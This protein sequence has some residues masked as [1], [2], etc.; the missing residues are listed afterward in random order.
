MDELQVNA[1]ESKPVYRVSAAGLDPRDVRLIE[2]VFKHSQYNPFG[3]VLDAKLDPEA[4]DILIV[5][6]AESEGLRAVARVRTVGR[7]VPVISAVPRGAPS[8][9][10]HAISIDRLTLQLL[11]ILNRVV[12]LELDGG[13]AAAVPASQPAQ[14][15]VQSGVPRSQAVLPQA[16]PA[17]PQAEPVIP[18]AES[19][20]PRIEPAMPRV[21]PA[22]P[23]AEAGIPRVEASMPRAGAG[24]PSVE[25]DT[26]QP[27]SSVPHAPAA[28]L[29]PLPQRSPPQPQPAAAASATAATP[30]A[31][32]AMPPS[33]PADA[34]FAQSPAATETATSFS[35]SLAPSSSLQLP[36]APAVSTQVQAP[37]TPA[38]PLHLDLPTRDFLRRAADKSREGDQLREQASRNRWQPEV[39]QLADAG[40]PGLQWMLRKPDT[41][42]PPVPPLDVSQAGAPQARQVPESR[43]SLPVGLADLQLPDL[44]LPDLRLPERAP[45]PPGAVGQPGAPGGAAVQ[46]AASGQGMPATPD[47]VQSVPQA[48]EASNAP[49]AAA[50]TATATGA[51]AGAGAGAAAP[52]NL[53]ALPLNTEVPPARIRVLV[54]DDS[55]TVRQQLARAFARMAII[56]DAAAS[57]AEALQRLAERHFDLVLVDVVMPDV[58]GYKLTRQIRR[59]HRGTPVIILTSRSSPFDLARG[60][61]AGCHTYLVKPVPLKQ[62]ESAVA[63]LLRKSLAIDDLT[64]MIRLSSDAPAKAPEASRAPDASG[65]PNPRSPRSAGQ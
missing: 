56:C 59:K 58:D 55:P 61:L 20:M 47:R 54:V 37:G 33:S 6:P 30:Q 64:G 12:E 11:P 42:L 51:G 13:R 38:N 19:A 8:T 46:S 28:Q 9:G 24:M 65:A 57:A 43:S 21:E 32:G 35:P 16:E 25:P 14:P 31:T 15:P 63:K 27:R 34:N 1:A 3:F 23:R 36:A 17:R 4:V 62:L 49:A 29:Q 48:P 44:N 22:V 10:R 45:M 26:A 2:I 50:P 40:P 5:N 60:A 41:G 53:V 39:G 18:R 52:S 7:Q